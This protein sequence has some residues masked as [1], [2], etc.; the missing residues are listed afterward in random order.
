MLEVTS[1]L[2]IKIYILDNFR[3]RAKSYIYWLNNR[4]NV[5][6]AS[7]EGVQSLSVSIYQVML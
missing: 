3:P 2:C 4:S 1:V 5:L 6:D 7:S